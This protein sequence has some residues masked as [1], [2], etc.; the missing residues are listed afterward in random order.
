MMLIS[1]V[2]SFEGMIS[3][4]CLVAPGFERPYELEISLDSRYITNYFIRM[5]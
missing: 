2:G 1:A 5:D 3:G 4:G